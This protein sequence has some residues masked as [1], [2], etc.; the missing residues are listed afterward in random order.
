MSVLC[1]VG[2][3]MGGTWYT[4]YPTRAVMLKRGETDIRGKGTRMKMREKRM[5]LV[6]ALWLG[7]ILGRRR[8]EEKGGRRGKKRKQKEMQRREEMRSCR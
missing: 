5:G 4:L 8:G 2:D 7:G 1:L 6:V 3:V